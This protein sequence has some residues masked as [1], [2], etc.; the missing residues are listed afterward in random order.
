MSSIACGG[1]AEY[2][3]LQEKNVALKVSP[4]RL[5]EQLGHPL[6]DMVLTLKVIFPSAS[7]TA[8]RTRRR[9][10]CRWSARLSIS[11]WLRQPRSRKAKQCSSSEGAVVAVRF[12][13]FHLTANERLR[14]CV[15]L[16]ARVHLLL[17]GSVA[18]QLAKHYKCDVTATCSQRN[19][20]FV[21]AL[22][23]DHSVDYAHENWWETLKGGNFDIIY[24]TV[25]GQGVWDHAQQV[26]KKDGIF[27][28]IATESEEK[29]PA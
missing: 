23:A 22:G 14:F 12:P 17:P 2:V 6:S 3:I 5:L 10:A 28:T 16:L 26:L 15:F 9:P 27:V 29:V 19:V 8:C 11:L 7:R 25:G 13:A 21:R 1:A 24:D 4:A 20:E 18:V